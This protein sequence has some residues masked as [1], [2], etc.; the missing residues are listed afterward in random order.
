M[1]QE[2]SAPQAAKLLEVRYGIS[3]SQA[4]R[5]IREAKTEGK[6]RPVPGRKMAFTV[7][8]SQRLIDEVRQKAQATGKSISDIVTQA[9]EAFLYKG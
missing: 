2:G 8:L 5:Y 6:E 1:K 9:L 3:R 4:Y 7:K